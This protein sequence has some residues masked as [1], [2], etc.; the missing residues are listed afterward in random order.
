EE[1]DR[2]V[3]EQQ[4]MAAPGLLVTAAFEGMELRRSL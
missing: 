3:A 2:I 1:L 4:A